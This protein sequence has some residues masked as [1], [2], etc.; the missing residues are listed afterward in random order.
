LDSQMVFLYGN[1]MGPSQP[2]PA[3]PG[4]G[5]FG[6]FERAQRLCQ[7]VRDNDLGGL[8]WGVEGIVRMNAGFEMIWCNFSSPS[9]RLLSHLNVTAPLLPPE[10]LPGDEDVIGIDQQKLGG[11]VPDLK[12]GSVC[13]THT[14]FPLPSSIVKKACSRPSLVRPPDWKEWAREPF[15]VSGMYEWF[16]SATWH[17]GSSGI[18]PGRAE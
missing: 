4:H 7:W 9:I 2:E 3:G 17:Y 8:G 10:S 13:S 6:E 5:L 11:R 14:M 12:D 18:G 15:T 16:R 1:T